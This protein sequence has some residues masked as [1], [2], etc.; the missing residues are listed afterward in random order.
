MKSSLLILS[1]PLFCLKMK[2]SNTRTSLL[3]GIMPIFGDS[4]DGKVVTIMI[5]TIDCNRSRELL[6]KLMIQSSLSIISLL[7]L[8]ILPYID[9]LPF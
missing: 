2:S 5:D 1:C 4:E 7:S 6:C 8:Y 3:I 9:N